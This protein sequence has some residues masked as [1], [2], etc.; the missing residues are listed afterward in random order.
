MATNTVD[1][2]LSVGCPV[3]EQLF[4]VSANPVV[5]QHRKENDTEDKPFFKHVAV[6]LCLIS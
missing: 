5:S 2:K 1:F 4:H 3:G 6:L